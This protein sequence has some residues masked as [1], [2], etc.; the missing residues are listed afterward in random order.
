MANNENEENQAPVIDPADLENLPEK[1]RKET[2]E[3]LGTLKEEGTPKPPVAGEKKGGEE[4]PPK[5]PEAELNADGTPKTKVEDKPADTPAKPPARREASVVPAWK[6][7][8]AEDQKGKAEERAQ[9]AEEI[10]AKALEDGKKPDEVAANLETE[11]AKIAEETGMPIEA[12]KRLGKIFAPAADPRIDTVVQ[13]AER[14]EAEAA[15]LVEVTNYNA[16]FDRDVLP[17]IAKE[18]GDASGK[19]PAETVAKIK[20]E[21]AKIAYTP[22][23]A[24][25]PYTEIYRGREDFRGIIP[26]VGAGGEGSRPGSEGAQPRVEAGQEGK[27]DWTKLESDSTFAFS[28]DEL[29]TLDTATLD[30]YFSILDKRK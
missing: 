20:E 16:D 2:E 7:K 10:A 5:Q 17:L 24:K 15:A 30:K 13:S 9:T 29:K 11:L 6:L 25:I 3:I 19:V 22:E 14:R 12:L 1:E 28:D 23:Y 18:Y 4:V 8:V 21:M 26:P 27:L